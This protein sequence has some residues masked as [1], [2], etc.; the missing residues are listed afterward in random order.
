MLVIHS[1]YKT[2]PQGRVLNI[3]FKPLMEMGLK[4]CVLNILYKH[5]LSNMGQI[6]V[7]KK[8]MRYVTF[9]GC[10]LSDSVVSQDIFF[11]SP[12]SVTACF[13]GS[14]LDSTT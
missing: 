12:L 3:L 13:S 10:K 1:M 5:A 11:L 6:F 7:K 9:S 14:P 4:I 8:C 2:Y